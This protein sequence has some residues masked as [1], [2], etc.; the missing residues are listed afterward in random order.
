[1]I[2]RFDINFP[3]VTELSKKYSTKVINEKDF[4]ELYEK[5]KPVIAM[6]DRQRKIE[7]NKLIREI[8]YGQV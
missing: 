1:M 7:L 4:E 5:G 6:S 3:T 8:K 2:K